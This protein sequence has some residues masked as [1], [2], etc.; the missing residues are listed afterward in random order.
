VPRAGIPVTFTWGSGPSAI[1]CTGVTDGL[2]LAV[3]FQNVNTAPGV[4]VPV[5]GAFRAY[6]R[7]YTVATSYAVNGDCAFAYPDFCLPNGLPP[8]TCAGIPYRNFIVLQ[9]EPHGFDPDRNG[10]GCEG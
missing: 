6:G 3:C 8:Q 10:L 4:V 7:N 1:Q 2:G 5:T 9:P